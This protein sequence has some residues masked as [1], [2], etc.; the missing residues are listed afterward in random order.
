MLLYTWQNGM[1]KNCILLQCD[2][3]C[4]FLCETHI[5]TQ[6]QWNDKQKIIKLVTLRVWEEV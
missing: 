3:H 5:H 4:T 2:S 6:K 1:R